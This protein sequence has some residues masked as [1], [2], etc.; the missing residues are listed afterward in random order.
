[1][2]IAANVGPALGR[3]VADADSI[4]ELR[5]QAEDWNRCD[6]TRMPRKTSSAKAL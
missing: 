3:E 4:A 2:T 1:M 5:H 6:S